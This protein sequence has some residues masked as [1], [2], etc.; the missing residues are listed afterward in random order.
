M[1]K[2]FLALLTVIM[3]Q[4]A[5]AQTSSVSEVTVSNWRLGWYSTGQTL[6]HRFQRPTYVERML[7]SAEGSRNFAKAFV[8]ADGDQVA[9]L[10]VP[11]RDPD[12][13]VIVR[14]AVSSIVIKFEGDVRI[15][16]FRLYV[17]EG[18]TDS[19]NRYSVG[20]IETPAQ[21]GKAVLRVIAD[22]QNYVSDTE[23]KNYLLP[24]R[25]S[26]LL[27]AAKGQG[28]PQLSDNTQQ[29]ARILVSQ[30][31]RTELFLMSRLAQSEFFSDQIQI[32][33]YAKEKLES[34]YEI[35]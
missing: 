3:A 27:L 16:D 28:R 20:S 15:L 5:S 18:P 6:V 8:Y 21:I 14:K 2:I 34:I 33:L 13:P 35:R 10:G 19:Y 23:F 22:L 4:G 11:G 12:Y 32:L 29:Q 17:A 30:L 25:Q 1:K 26:A 7:I 9:L 24:L 31:K